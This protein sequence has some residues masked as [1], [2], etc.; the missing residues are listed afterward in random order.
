M[1]KYSRAGQTTDNILRRM[2]IACWTNKATD[3]HSEY[4]RLVAFP[5]QQWLLERASMLR[6]TYVARLVCR[7]VRSF[8]NIG[9]Q[10]Y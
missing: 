2:S 7:E 5:R 8:P 9:V 4:V 6:K 10:L 3:T 1:E